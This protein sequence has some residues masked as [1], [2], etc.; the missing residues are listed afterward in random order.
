[1]TY[2]FTKYKKDSL[3]KP[4]DLAW[5]NWA[6]FEKVGDKVQGFIRDVFYRAEE[7]QYKAQRGITLEQPNGEMINVAIKRLP[8]VLSKT[9]GLRLGDPLTVV[10][11]S[12]LPAKQKGF[13]KT[14][15]MGYYGTNLEENADNKTVRELDAEDR[16]AQGAEESKADEEF[17]AFGDKP[18]E[19]T[20]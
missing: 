17:D 6:K 18:E 2:D 20:A 5:E 4:R 8:F 15:V 3:T 7:G 16:D 1:M 19:A 12:E 9:D 13:S 14:K 11:D 10:F